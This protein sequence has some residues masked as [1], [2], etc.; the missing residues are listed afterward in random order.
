MNLTERIARLKDLVQFSLV[1]E[2]MLICGVFLGTKVLFMGFLAAIRYFAVVTSLCYEVVFEEGRCLSVCP[3]QGTQVS[4]SCSTLK[5]IIITFLLE[6]WKFCAWCLR[7]L[8]LA[9]HKAEE[10][11]DLFL[12]G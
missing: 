4:C 7:R 12:S 8:F 10:K 3:P 6:L 1:T 2:T 11:R 5:V 9:W